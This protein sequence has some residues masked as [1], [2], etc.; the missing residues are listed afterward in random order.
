MR[1]A[2]QAISWTALVL[3]FL[4]PALYL[5]GRWELSTAQATMGLATLVWFIITPFWMGRAKDEP[6]AA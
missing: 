3:T 4:P 1:I 5:F 2:L 6:S